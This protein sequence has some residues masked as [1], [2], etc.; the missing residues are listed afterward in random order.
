MKKLI[1]A[2]ALMTVL[3]M[4]AAALAYNP[5]QN[6]PYDAD[7]V[8]VYVWT[9]TAWHLYQ[10]EDFPLAR[11]WTS[12]S[13]EGACNQQNWP[14][15][16]TNH[17]SVAQWIDWD[18]S[19]TRWDWHVMKPGT[20]AADCIELEVDS[21]NDVK[22]LFSNFEDLQYLEEAPQ[23]TLTEIATWYAIGNKMGE[24][25]WVPADELDRYQYA[26][27]NS[28]QLHD[29]GVTLKFWNKIEVLP[30]NSSCEYESE[31]TITLQLQN[32]K[33]WVDGTDGDWVDP[34]P[35]DEEPQEP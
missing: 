16:F 21:N 32:I 23:G 7:E 26:I 27:Y 20:Y 24:L 8:D 15:T 3:L 10:T 30:C 17:A 13:A 5:G 19:G 2:L 1:L 12:G 11:C 22:I 33:I 4:P 18:I 28:A 31:G 6:L 14:F 9:G 35:Q 25:V 29:P 34:Q